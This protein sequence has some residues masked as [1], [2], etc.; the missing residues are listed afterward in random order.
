MRNTRAIEIEEDIYAYLCS[1][2]TEFGETPSSILR[3]LL[4]VPKSGSPRE[5]PDES[6]EPIRPDG[7]SAPVDPDGAEGTFT[8]E[9]EGESSDLAQASPQNAPIPAS[10][11]GQFLTTR[12]FTDHY[13]ALGRFLAVLTWLYQRHGQ[14]FEAVTRVRGRRRVYFAENPDD[15]AR[16]GSSTMPHPVPGTPWYVTTNTSTRLKLVILAKLLS[17]LGYPKADIAL[18]AAAVDPH[19]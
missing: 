18:V 1:Q 11:L 13:Q 2:T 5:T 15:I 6:A 7:H 3:R 4:H 19:R 16:S 14:E 10:E 9:D 12:P 8:V 17:R